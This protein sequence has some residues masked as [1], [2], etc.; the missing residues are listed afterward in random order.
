MP[1]PA[2]LLNMDHPPLAKTDPDL[3]EARRRI[4]PQVKRPSHVKRLEKKAE[5]ARPLTEIEQR[6]ERVKHGA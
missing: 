2:A 5:K 4:Q 1:E 6:A 3:T